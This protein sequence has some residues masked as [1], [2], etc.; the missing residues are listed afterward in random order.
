MAYVNVAEWSPDQVTEWLKGLDNVIIPYINSFLNNGVKGHQLLNLRA[1]DLEHL[2]VYTLGH[3]ELI[4]EA[5]EHLRNFHYELDRENL[6]LLALRLSCAAHSLYNELSST[7]DNNKVETQTMADVANI[8]STIK[9]LVC[10][11]D[12]SPFSGQTEYNDRKIEL[13]KL[14]V[15]MATCAHRDRFAERPVAAIRGYCESLAELADKIIQDISDPMLLQPASLDLATLKKRENDLGFFI[16]PSFRNVHQIAEIKFGSPAHTSGKI[17]EGDEI[18][19]VNYQTVVGWERKKVLSLFQESPPDVLLTLKKRPRHTKI[20]GQIYMKPYRLPSKKRSLPYN[21]WHDNLPSPRPELLTI[22]DFEIPLPRVPSGGLTP[23]LPPACSSDSDSCSSVSDSDGSPPQSLCPRVYPLKPRPVLQRRNTI[24]GAIPF[25]RAPSISIEQFWRELKIQASYKHSSSGFIQSSTDVESNKEGLLRD[26]SVSYGHGLELNPRPST[27][28]GLASKKSSNNSK[29]KRHLSDDNKCDD[30]MRERKK[31]GV[32]FVDDIA[33]SKEETKENTGVYEDNALHVKNEDSLKFIDDNEDEVQDRSNLINEVK[34]DETLQIDVKQKVSSFEDKI[35]QNNIDLKDILQDPKSRPVPKTRTLYQPDLKNDIKEETLDV[36]PK[37]EHKFRKPPEI[38]PKPSTLKKPAVPPRNFDRI[39]QLRGRLDKSHS[40]PAYDLSDGTDV[41]GIETHQKVSQ[42]VIDHKKDEQHT[43]EKVEV[44]DEILTGKMG[45]IL[46][47]INSS[48]ITYRQREQESIREKS[49]PQEPYEPFVPRNLSKTEESPQLH[50]RK[51][52]LHSQSEAPLPPPRPSHTFTSESPK[53]IVFP[54]KEVDTFG[55]VFNQEPQKIS[56]VQHATKTK[57]TMDETT[58]LK[59]P[60]STAHNK[61]DNKCEVKVSSN[62]VKAIISKGKTVRKKNSLY[63]KRRKVSVKDVSPGEIQGYLYQRIRNKTT[64]NV[65]WIKRWFIL[66]GSAL[67]GFKSKDASKAECVVFLPGFTVSLATEVKSRTNAFKVYHTGT[68][69]YLSADNNETML[70][71]VDVITSATLTTDINLSKSSDISL[72]SETDESEDEEKLVKHEKS[73]ASSSPA[74]KFGSLKKFTSRKHSDASTT[75]STATTT[76]SPGSTSLDRKYLRFFNSHS[77]TKHSK[78]QNVPVP[79]AQFRSYRKVIPPLLVV[80]QNV[81]PPINI[82]KNVDPVVE[83]KPDL[84]HNMPTTTIEEPPKL[85]PKPLKLIPKPKPINYIHASNPSLCDFTDYKLP[86]FVPKQKNLHRNDNLSGFITLEQFMLNRQEE[87]RK[88][89]AFLQRQNDAVEEEIAETIQEVKNETQTEHKKLGESH[90][91]PY[92]TSDSQ[93]DK[94][95]LCRKYSDGIADKNTELRNRLSSQESSSSRPLSRVKSRKMSIDSVF[96]DHRSQQ[97][98]EWDVISNEAIIEATTSV[99][100]KLK[101]PHPPTPKHKNKIIRQHSLNSADKKSESK[102]IFNR[103]DSPEKFWLNSLRRNDK[104]FFSTPTHK[105]K[106]KLKSA[107]QYTPMNYSF[108][109]DQKLNPKLAFE[110]NLDEKST[111]SSKFK[112]LFGGGS[113]H[114]T[115][116]DSE[117]HH[118]KEKTLL[119]S[120]R[121]HRAIFRKNHSPTRETDWRGDFSQASSSLSHL[122]HHNHHHHHHTLPLSHHPPYVVSSATTASSTVIPVSVIQLNQSSSS[123][124]NP[125]PDYPDLEYPP[126]F[127]PETYSLSNPACSLLRKQMNNKQ[128]NSNSK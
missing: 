108:S 17:E 10:W 63:A 15:L 51:E 46:E 27:V 5:V 64:Q 48:L 33:E 98:S 128:N 121:L 44:Y 20:Y 80:N 116:S 56:N 93:A 117:K 11:L 69:F 65:N 39:A 72:Y 6:Q 123:Q 114:K 52:R 19:Q 36:F 22:P 18:V 86:A 122:S 49:E 30:K 67:Y 58:K 120:P 9:P 16:L 107:T 77:S 111:K 112:S 66:N 41:Y 31:T 87:E 113:S 91:Y 90:S 47:T 4:L 84:L 89:N 124:S 103:G 96:D 45:E 81:P 105:E 83:K 61:R 92:K 2:G 85:A 109:A 119:G 50:P 32:R 75:S 23:Q 94:N 78:N 59:S 57:L 28:I 8:I 102:S 14:S 70:T 88:Q 127:E 68:A 100:S 99:Q 53:Q 13:L 12:R 101:K 25:Y 42:K 82:I 35:S 106:T 43:E 60:E 74:R 126:I 73:E 115:S 34:A 7:A 37:D 97:D 76:D 125:P 40:T 24:T 118:T 1:D 21:R 29:G 110:L 95:V 104:V 54:Q 62:P 26:K 38:P 3:Q 71:W 55:F 79:T